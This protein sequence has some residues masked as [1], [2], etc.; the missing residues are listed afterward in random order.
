VLFLPKRAKPTDPPQVV[1]K[2]RV[3]HFMAGSEPGNHLPLNSLTTTDA[4]SKEPDYPLDVPNFS[5]PC[6]P[7]RLIGVY[8]GGL[9]ATRSVYR[10]AGLCK[11]R[12]GGPTRK[13]VGTGEF[14]H[15]CK[16]LIVNRVNPGLHAI[17]DKSYPE[18]KKNG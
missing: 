2:D 17:L 3:R 4:I 6:R 7:Y 18:A 8:E 9:H 10:P 14:C 1:L 5:E 13:D 12:A 15:V 11:M 16:W